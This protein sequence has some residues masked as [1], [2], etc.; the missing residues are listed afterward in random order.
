MTPLTCT[1]KELLLEETLVH[2]KLTQSRSLDFPDSFLVYFLPPPL[3]PPPSVER[4][5]VLY[6]RRRGLSPHLNHVAEF[7]VQSLDH[8][9]SHYFFYL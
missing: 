3:P 7:R 4:G 5:T 9:L 2:S 1:V 8:R 6:T